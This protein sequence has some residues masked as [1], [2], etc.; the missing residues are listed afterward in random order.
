LAVGALAAAASA[1]ITLTRIATIDF[2]GQIT[3]D[4]ITSVAWDG[5]TAY[6]GTYRNSA[7]NVAITAADNALGTP[8]YRT[9]GNFAINA[10]LG[11]GGLHIQGGILAATVNPNA[12]ASTNFAMY[13]AAAG[14]LIGNAPAGVTTGFGG[15]PRT[16]PSWD[17]INGAFAFTAFNSGRYRAVAPDGSAVWTDAAGP[18]NFDSAWGTAWFDTDIDGAGN[19]Y[20]REG[21]KII[22]FTRT[23]P[24]TFQTPFSPAMNLL[25]QYNASAGDNSIGLNLQILEDFGVIL[26]N[27]R[28]FTV[29]QLAQNVYKAIDL[30][31]APVTINFANVPS[32]FL[33]NAIYDYSYDPA[34]RTLAAAE[35]SSNRVY[36]Y[37]VTPEPTTLSLLLLGAVGLIRR[38]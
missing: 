31:G 32:D 20:S 1:D 4:N 24:N 6:V 27:D 19:V 33:S 2:N 23:G 21:F 9:F 3:G 25:P 29:N 30:S 26:W 12:N 34:T 35:F 36:I 7:G 11:Y 18:F 22:K 13:N 37:N 15:G 16:G 38:R 14:T 10:F 17:P 5:S 28:L 8:A